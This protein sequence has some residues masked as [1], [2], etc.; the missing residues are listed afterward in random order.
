MRWAALAL[1]ALALAGCETSAEKSAKLEREA[2]L[3]PAA[4]AATGL[5]I[6]RASSKVK[7][8][9]AIL[10]TGSEGSAAVVT[11]QND[12]AQTLR[13]IPVAV[14]VKG[15]GGATV[16]TNT[17]PGVGHTLTSASLIAPHGT[18]VWV[19]DQV[20]AAGGTAASVSARVGEVSSA[21]GATPRL[22]VR[23]VQLHE[24]PVNGLG[25]Q[26]ELVN[27]SSVAQRELVV[28]AIARKGGRI[29]AAGRAVIPQAAPG[30]ATHFQ[31]FFVGEV[32]GA[33]LQ[34]TAPPTTL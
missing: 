9:S 6:A 10:I 33:S 23:G 17:T 11:L 4:K 2:K 25:A 15:A 8:A 21:P 7:V 3:H 30:A 5:T 24:D 18:L 16:Y 31:V 34:L 14:Y 26:G 1:A 28:Y 32:K 27:E 20:Q 12:S 22:S 19:D 13:E 29:V